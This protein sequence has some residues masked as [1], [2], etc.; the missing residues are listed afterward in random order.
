MEELNLAPFIYL[1]SLTICGIMASFFAGRYSVRREQLKKEREQLAEESSKIVEKI[2]EISAGT[3]ALLRK[4][5]GPGNELGKVYEVLLNARGVYKAMEDY[6]SDEHKISLYP[7]LDHCMK[8]LEEVIA[9]MPR[10]IAR[11]KKYNVM[12]EWAEWSMQQ[13]GHLNDPTSAL[14]HLKDE[15]DEALAEPFKDSE[16]ADLMGLVLSAYRRTG[17]TSLMLLGHMQEKLQKNRNRNWTW[18]EKSGFYEGS[19]D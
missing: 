8:R 2:N 3:E 15:V 19:E 9:V 10:L 17:K 5:R 1:A 4:V 7:G 13:F 14:K 11:Q 6:V 18:N 16:Y 12:D